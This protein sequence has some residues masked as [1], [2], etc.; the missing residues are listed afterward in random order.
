MASLKDSHVRAILR[1]VRTLSTRVYA[2][3]GW[4]WRE[5]VYREA[6]A[7]ELADTGLDV[8]CEQSGCIMYKGQALSHV[9]IRMDLVVA[10]KVAVEL[11]AVVRL[12]PRHMRQCSR[13]VENVAGIEAGI[14]VNFPDRANSSIEACPVLLSC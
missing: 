5:E 10:G 12:A 3:L 8:S 6:L 13:Y 11:K 7:R 4:G 9:G 2:E 1:L 14:I